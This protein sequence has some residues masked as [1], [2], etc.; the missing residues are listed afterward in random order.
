L[1]L[2]LFAP[3]VLL[4]NLFFFGGSEVVLDVER[5]SDFVGGLAFDHVRHGFAGD[6]EKS[7][8]VEVI[9]SEDEFEQGSLIDF[10]ELDV[11][12]GDVIGPLLAIVVIFGR[13]SIVLVIR[14]PLNHFLENGGVDIGKRD[15][16]V[17]FIVHSQ[18]LQHG[19]D[20]DGE[21]GDLDVNLEDLAVGALQLDGRHLSIVNCSQVKYNLFSAMSLSQDDGS[22]SVAEIFKQIE[23]TQL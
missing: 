6:I 14:A 17:V 2:L 23:T 11:P 1:S 9:G 22:T 7:F 16:L 15:S 5:F 20:G 19:F 3:L 21:F 18:I 10:E 12:G 8:N 4:A 13:R